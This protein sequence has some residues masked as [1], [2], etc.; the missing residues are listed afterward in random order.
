VQSQIYTD[1]YLM[2][3][4][5]A[6]MQIGASSADITKL[7]NKTG[8]AFACH[9]NNDAYA[10][11]GQPYNK[12]DSFDWAQANGITLKFKLVNDGIQNFMSFLKTQDPSGQYIRVKLYSFDDT[13]HTLSSLTNNFDLI[14][15]NLPTPQF[16]LDELVS[17]THFNELVPLVQSA[18]GSS[19]DG[20]TQA[21]S[22][23]IFMLASDGIQDPTRR[24]AT[25]QPW[26]QVQVAPFDFTFCTQLQAKGVQVGILDTGYVPMPW[27]WGYMATVGASSLISGHSGT[28]QQDIAP[29][30]KACAGD[31]Y[32]DGSNGGN[33]GTAFQ[34]MF[35]TA[36]PLR[37]A[38]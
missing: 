13:L 29:L 37:I 36:Q 26:L 3:D 23:K 6:S 17:S 16:V 8:C 9:D 33:I 34:Q 12:G 21:K 28:R 15:A 27:D 22:K 35:T 4:Q 31:I 32:V 11:A 20:S 19:G 7:R 10:V 38:Q 5:S 18:V 2:I 30:M 25:D 24:W 14:S 1:I